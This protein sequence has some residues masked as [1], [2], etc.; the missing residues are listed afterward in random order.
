MDVND[1]LVSSAIFVSVIFVGDTDARWA[2]SFE[3]GLERPFVGFLRLL[4]RFPVLSL[5]ELLLDAY[6]FGSK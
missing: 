2:Q 3:P 4:L 6:Y 5:V 1:G